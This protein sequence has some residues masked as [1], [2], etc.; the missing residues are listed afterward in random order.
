MKMSNGYSLICHE[1]KTHRS[2]CTYSGATGWYFYWKDN[3][4]EFENSMRTHYACVYNHGL[5]I[6]E[7]DKVPESYDD[8]WQMCIPKDFTQKDVSEAILHLSHHLEVAEKQ[9][10]ILEIQLKN[11]D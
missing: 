2:F 7:D 10:R 4:G 5:T 11:K 1:C 3:P 8:D 9:I 6:I